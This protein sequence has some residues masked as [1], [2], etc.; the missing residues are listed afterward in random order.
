[1]GITIEVV[2]AEYL[3]RSD[4]MGFNCVSFMVK[5]TKNL[6]TKEIIEKFS[7]LAVKPI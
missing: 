1:M 5:Q 3:N 7:N 2:N 6:K 4:L